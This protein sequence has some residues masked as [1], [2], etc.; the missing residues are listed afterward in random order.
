MI[1]I[2]CGLLVMM[3]LSGCFGSTLFQIGPI[4]IKTGDIL[5]KP[6]TKDILKDEK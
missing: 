4:P 6:I 1:K 3:L 5:S 2:I